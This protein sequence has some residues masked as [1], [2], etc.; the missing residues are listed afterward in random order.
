MGELCELCEC[1]RRR[2]GY[3]GELCGL[4][5]QSWM[6]GGGEVWVSIWLGM[7]ALW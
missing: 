3:M 5:E 6:H 4:C 7:V 1:M 2:Y